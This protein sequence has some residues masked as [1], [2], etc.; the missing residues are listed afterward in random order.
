[1][2]RINREKVE[3]YLF[4][5]VAVTALGAVAASCI[6]MTVAFS[7]ANLPWMGWGLAVV[8]VLQNGAF[9]ALASINQVTVIRRAVFAGMV[10]L[11]VC[12]WMG[13]Y[14]AGGLIAI[15]HVP[16]ELSRLFFNL[17][18][19]TLIVIGTILFAS[20]LPVLNLITIFALSE[21]AKRLVEQTGQPQSVNPWA[22][23]VMQMRENQPANSASTPNN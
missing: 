8:T 17:D 12:E 10:L 2:R 16:T 18:H 1:M 21:A 22:E 14:F 11:S 15:R 23:M 7:W 13:N 19:N 3:L 9:V 6:H 5:F 4:L 20:S